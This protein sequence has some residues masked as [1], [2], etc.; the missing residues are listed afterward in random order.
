MPEGG[1]VVDVEKCVGGCM[2]YSKHKTCCHVIVGR[3][4]KQTWETWCRRCNRQTLQSSGSKS[5]AWKPKT[6]SQ[7]AEAP[8]AGCNKKQAPQ[9]R[10][11]LATQA[12]GLQFI[13]CPDT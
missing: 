8:A 13:L 5:E 12:L 9:G 10:P 6:A 1:W 3:K 2:F 7:E 11:P 4:A